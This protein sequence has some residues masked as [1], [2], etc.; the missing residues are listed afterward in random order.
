[1]TSARGFSIRIFIPSGSPD[2][3]RLVSKS[4]WCGLGIEFP[5]VALIEAQKDERLAQTGVYVL[6]DPFDAGGL[7]RVYIGEADDV[8]QRLG[9]PDHA[10]RDFWTRAIAFVSKDQTLNKAHAKFIEA[11]L[12]NRAKDIG[13]YVLDNKQTPSSYSLSK[14]DKEDALAFLDD[15]LLC[16]RA[17]GYDGFERDDERGARVPSTPQPPSLPD[18]TSLA[19]EYTVSGKRVTAK[20]YETPSGG[21][22][23]LADSTASGE[24][25]DAWFG[26]EGGAVS[27]RETLIGR[28]VL[29]EIAPDGDYVFTENY[30]FRSASLAVGIILAGSYSGPQELK[31]ADGRSLRENRER[32]GADAFD[33]P[34][35]ADSGENSS[36]DVPADPSNP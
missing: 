14:E 25:A 9:Q 22:L 2:G 17:L 16:L 35:T 18:A 8:A 26:K 11:N 29:K 31:D 10:K 1:M 21:F 24:P 12:F 6:I 30:E 33:V 27:L 36:E 5:R 3:V 19:V 15:V 13:K 20:G 23:V 7:P 32:A 4:N 28:G 34:D